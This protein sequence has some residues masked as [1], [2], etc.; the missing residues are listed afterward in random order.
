MVKREYRIATYE[1]GARRKIDEKKKRR[2][3]DIDIVIYFV[4]V[5]IDM[6]MS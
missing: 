2:S 3:I 1:D 4:H 6:Y 5:I